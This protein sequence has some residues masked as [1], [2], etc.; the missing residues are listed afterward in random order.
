MYLLWVGENNVVGHLL[1]DLVERRRCGDAPPQGR[2]AT[3]TRGAEPIAS[4]QEGV[5]QTTKGG[6]QSSR[7]PP[8][9]KKGVFPLLMI[10]GSSP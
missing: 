1:R 7:L 6:A 3:T 4:A 2:A 8:N 5:R 10:R 9:D